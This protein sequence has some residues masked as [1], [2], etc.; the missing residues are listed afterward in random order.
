MPL[1]KPKAKWPD[2]RKPVDQWTFAE[3][4]GL[5]LCACVTGIGRHPRSVTDEDWV[6]AAENDAKSVGEAQFITDLL[7]ITRQTIPLYRGV[8]PVS[9]YPEKSTQET[10]PMPK[11]SYPGDRDWNDNE[12]NVPMVEGILCNPLYAGIPGVS[13]QMVDDATWVRAAQRIIQENGLRQYL[14]NFLYQLKKSMKSLDG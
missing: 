1:L 13:E 11:S 6:I 10:V 4:R 3:Q 5:T 7:H 8:A 12:W 14:T 9:N 2:L